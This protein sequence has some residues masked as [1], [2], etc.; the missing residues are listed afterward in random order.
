[1]TSGYE[2]RFSILKLLP[3]EKK[4]NLRCLKAQ[5]KLAADK[6]KKDKCVHFSDFLEFSL[7]ILLR[8]KF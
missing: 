3:N 5:K 1:M 4:N 2:F 8:S 6:N 7:D